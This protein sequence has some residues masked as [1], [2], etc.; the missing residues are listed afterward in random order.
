SRCHVEAITVLHELD[1]SL[2]FRNNILG[3]TPRDFAKVYEHEKAIIE[4]TKL[5]QME[6]K[7]A[8][9]RTIIYILP[10]VAVISSVAIGCFLKF[11]RND[12]YS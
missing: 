1:S 8:L 9:I 3:F 12:K 7:K 6:R 4:I 2:I 5:H 10:Y 11:C